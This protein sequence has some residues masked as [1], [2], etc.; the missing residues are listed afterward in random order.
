MSQKIIDQLVLEGGG[1][2]SKDEAQAFRAV[3]D[4]LGPKFVNSYTSAALRI[5]V[6]SLNNARLATALRESGA[7]TPRLLSV[8]E[9]TTKWTDVVMNRAKSMFT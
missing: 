1:A 4:S 6:L 3:L 9:K 5:A 2:A 7:P 8:S